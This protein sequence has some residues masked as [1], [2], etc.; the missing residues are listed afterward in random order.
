MPVKETSPWDEGPLANHRIKRLNHLNLT[1]EERQ[2]LGKLMSTDQVKASDLAKYYSIPRKWLNTLHRK[3]RDNNTIC[4]TQGKGRPFLLNDK[5][6]D[7]LLDF[8][9]EKHKTRTATDTE[10]K[11]KCQTLYDDQCLELDIAPT[12]IIYVSNNFIKLMKKRL[13]IKLGP[14]QG[15]TKAR[16][17][18]EKDP[19]NA[20]SEYI[21]LRHLQKDKDPNLIGN[22]DATQYGVDRNGNV[23]KLVWIHSDTGP[24]NYETDG[25]L[26]LFIKVYMLGVQSGICAPMVTVIALDDMDE[27]DFISIKIPGMSHVATTGQYG[28]VCFTKTRGCNKKF[29]DWYFLTVLIPFF[30]QLRQDYELGSKDEYGHWDPDHTVRA[31]CTMD[32]EA[33]QTDSVFSEDVLL[34]FNLNLIDVGKHCASSSASTNAWDA[35]TFFKASKKA[36]TNSKLVDVVTEQGKCAIVKAIDKKLLENIGDLCDKTKRDKIADGILRIIVSSQKTLNLSSIVTGFKLTGQQPLNFAIKM[37][38]TYKKPKLSG[39]EWKHMQSNVV[40]DYLTEVFKAQGHIKEKDFDQMNIRRVNDDRKTDKDERVLHQQRFVLMTHNNTDARWREHRVNIN[41]LAVPRTE[42]ARLKQQQA[43]EDKERVKEAKNQQ[44][45]QKNINKEALEELKKKQKID[46]EVEKLKKSTE[47]TI[48]REEKNKR[49]AENKSNNDKAIKIAKVV[50]KRS[51]S[52]SEV[53]VDEILSVNSEPVQV[54]KISQ[55]GRVLKKKRLD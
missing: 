41:L 42:M 19:R 29:Y 2:W 55:S 26:L 34:S 10:F 12:H 8:L 47:A 17:D 39:T 14:G 30:N 51:S 11:E 23:L 33:K 38:A 1:T 32:G 31:L 9:H 49:K 18:A 21:C 22:L 40:L 5:S 13:K 27:N 35:A 37:N 53:V 16:F 46:K 45:I 3:A 7:L 25:E 54:E 15:K 48:E 43:F 36:L 24:V 44:K 6:L 28:Y 20:Y 52:S 50:R 4:N